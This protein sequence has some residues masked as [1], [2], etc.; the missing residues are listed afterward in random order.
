MMIWIGRR[1]DEMKHIVSFSGGKDSTAMLIMMIEKGMQIDEI[2][3]ADTKLEF[4]E[5]YEYID[6]VEDYIGRPIT[7]LKTHK[8]FDDWFYGKVTRGKNKG[9]QRG[10]PL[11]AYPCYWNRESKLNVLNKKCKGN[12]RYIG[13]ACDEPKRVRK[14]EGYIYPLVD[15]GVTESDCI[16]YLKERDM[17]N[18]LY[19][20]FD[21]LGCW[22]CP[23]QSISSLESLYFYYPELWEKLKQYEKD[24]PNGFRP[25]INLGEF[26]KRFS[27]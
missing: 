1:S 7:R 16:E 10:F 18:P 9:I 14:H 23:K 11:V 27:G 25:D 6:K 26:E 20:R 13:I 15:W 12:Y 4:P 22:L 17:L 21:R 8:N 2:V 24:D 3:F 19:E 5:M